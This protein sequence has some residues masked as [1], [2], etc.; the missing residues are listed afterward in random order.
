MTWVFGHIAGRVD[1]HY[2][3]RNDN[4]S[5]WQRAGQPVR[6]FGTRRVLWCGSLIE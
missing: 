6:T 1:V 4:R 3:N 5:N 2:A